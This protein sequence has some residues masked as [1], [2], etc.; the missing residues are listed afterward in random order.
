MNNLNLFYY[1]FN[2][3]PTCR[4]TACGNQRLTIKHY[5]HECPQLRDS[6]KKHNMQSDIRTLLVNNCEVQKMIRFLN[7]R[8]IL[9]NIEMI[10]G[11]RDQQAISSILYSLMI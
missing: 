2:Q 5:L 8:D 3:Q 9:E 7:E 11:C 1:Y 6:R 4:N 10:E